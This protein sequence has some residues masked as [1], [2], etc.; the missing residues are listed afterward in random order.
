MSPVEPDFLIGYV[1]VIRSLV[2]NNLYTK[3]GNLSFCKRDHGT[4][5]I[6]MD[7]EKVFCGHFI[8][9]PANHG[10]KCSSLRKL[11]SPFSAI[12]KDLYFKKNFERRT[13]HGRRVNNIN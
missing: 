12:F 10:D 2:A 8:G 1:I 7:M 4:C 6:C 13:S 9:S 11:P 3:F 5:G